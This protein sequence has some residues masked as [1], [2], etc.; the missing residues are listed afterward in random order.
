VQELRKRLYVALW[1]LLTIKTQ[2]KSP[3][4]TELSGYMPLRNEFEV[5]WDNNAEIK[6]KDIVFDEDDSPEQE[7]VK[8]TLL[9]C[10]HSRLCIRKKKGRYILF[11][12]HHSYI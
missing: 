1:S 5:E 9:E 12:L 4:V 7:A 3:I 10:Y 11:C 2:S 6:I 8:L